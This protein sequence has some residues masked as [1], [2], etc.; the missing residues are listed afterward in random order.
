MN[1][2]HNLINNHELASYMDEISET[3][4]VVISTHTPDQ[5]HVWDLDRWVRTMEW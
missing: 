1:T 4:C 2:C 5:I 3:M